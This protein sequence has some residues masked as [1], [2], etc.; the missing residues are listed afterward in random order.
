MLGLRVGQLCSGASLRTVVGGA[1]VRPTIVF[2]SERAQQL[3]LKSYPPNINHC[4]LGSDPLWNVEGY[5]IPVPF[6]LIRAGSRWMTQ[7]SSAT[8][9]CRLQ[10][11]IECHTVRIIPTAMSYEQQRKRV[12]WPVLVEA[13]G[14]ALA[15]KVC[16]DQPRPFE[17]VNESQALL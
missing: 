7:I 14:R 13:L 1:L 17:K 5:S 8:N 9:E 3:H 12:A 16:P 2:P 4:T 10:Y 6:V 11:L 15:A